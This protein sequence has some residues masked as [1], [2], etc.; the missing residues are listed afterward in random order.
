MGYVK[1]TEIKFE[2]RYTNEIQQIVMID[3]LVG[4]SKTDLTD[5][6]EL[7]GAKLTITDE[8]G[9]IIDEWASSKEVHYVTGLEEG[10]TYTL[11]EI[12]AP[13]GYEI[14]ESITFKVT[15]D[16]E[17]QIIEM[18][19]KPIVKT[20]KVQKL[21][22][23]TEENIKLN[24]FEFAIYEDEECTK[25]ITTANTNI[26]EG[27]VTFDSLRY[28]VYYIKEIKA[29]KGYQLSDKVVKIEINENGVFANDVELVNNEGIY[30]FNYYNLKIPEIPTIQTGNE[31]NYT[32]LV[33]LIGISL[34]GIIVG[35]I[36]IR[37]GAKNRE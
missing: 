37:R 17:T 28:G 7:E 1:A 4:I 21:D 26:L 18:K 20:I 10:K 29:P 5:G 24:N 33:S 8:E 2:V 30:S 13:Y 15:T 12:T 25:L 32:L 16:K 9:N 14:A 34:I 27:T 6:K 19:D 11:T 36:F 3:K 23:D 35:F 31:T 22:K